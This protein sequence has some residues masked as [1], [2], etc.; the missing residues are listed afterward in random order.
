MSGRPELW[1]LARV[2]S[3][4]RDETVVWATPSVWPLVRATLPFTIDMPPSHNLIVIGGGTLI[5]E[6]KRFVYDEAPRVRLI[7]IPSIWGSGAEASPVVV[8]NRD[9]R[10]E[11]RMGEEYL[12][13]ARA[14]WP[15]LAATLPAGRAREACGDAWAHAIEGFLSPL[16]TEE[17]RIEIAALMG[18]MI[19]VGIGNDARW[20]ELS[21]RAAAAQ[22]RS[23]VGLVHGIAHTLEP[24]LPGWGHARLCSTYLAPVLRFDRKGLPDGVE[25]EVQKLFDADRYKQTLPTLETAWRDV[26]RDRC[27]RTNAALV[28]P[29]DLQFFLDYV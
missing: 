28:R 20:F 26:L 8:L 18:E 11:I 9:G 3:L 15:E 21:A 1:P 27:T 25:A 16:A 7:A 6:A 4:D 2:E 12:P 22:A 10:K 23:S 5:D 14:V 13:H 24:L 17:L 29:A 19:A